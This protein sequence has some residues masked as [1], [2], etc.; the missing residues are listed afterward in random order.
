MKI[1]IFVITLSNL[2]LVDMTM[3]MMAAQC[4]VFFTAGFETS[5]SVQS[6]CLYELA[7]H[8]DIQ[9]RVQEELDRILFIHGGFTYE[10]VQ[11]MTYLDMVIAGTF[12]RNILYVGLCISKD[13][14][15][16]ALTQTSINVCC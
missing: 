1:N 14:K 7:L 6:C 8:Q 3:E 9:N 5:G 13:A 11:K 12:I 10:A 2:K 16:N 15:T 4:F